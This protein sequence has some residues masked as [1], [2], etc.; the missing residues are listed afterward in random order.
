MEEL[1]ARLADSDATIAQLRDDLEGAP[2]EAVGRARERGRPCRRPC[3]RRGPKRP[4]PP[5]PSSR[6]P[7]CN[8]RSTK[9]RA[10]AL[11]L[12]ALKRACVSKVIDLKSPIKG[13]SI[14]WSRKLELRVGLVDSAQ[15]EVYE[16]SKSA[17][18]ALQ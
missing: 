6:A 8:S 7:H 1:R 2:D 16:W 17:V 18:L 15:D 5:R 3:H 14:S 4:R 11:L 9:K 12:A 10:Y 13:A